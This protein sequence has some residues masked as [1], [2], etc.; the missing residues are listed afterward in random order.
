MYCSSLVQIYS[1]KKKCGNLPGHSNYIHIH[2]INVVSAGESL[3]DQKGSITVLLYDTC[4][5]LCDLLKDSDP[6]VV[7][8]TLI[9][10]RNSSLP[11][12]HTYKILIYQGFR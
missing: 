1:A 5:S 11:Y 2:K 10:I 12:T 6:G 8:L 4:Y 7:S 3:V 9:I